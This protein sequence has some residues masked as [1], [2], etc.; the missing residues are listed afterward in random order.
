MKLSSNNIK[1]KS[2]HQRKRRDFKRV[3]C[4]SLGNNHKKFVNI[5]NKVGT[6][7]INVT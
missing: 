1:D 7:N 2:P 5:I 3:D 6:G 4:S